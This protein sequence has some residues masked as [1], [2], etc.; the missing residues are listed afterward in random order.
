MSL[1]I[2]SLKQ[3]FDGKAIAL[4]QL[5]DP[6]VADLIKL[7]EKSLH[8]TFNP[9]GLDAYGS[10]HRV[11]QGGIGFSADEP[12]GTEHVGNCVAVIARDPLSGKTGLAHYDAL[13]TPESLQCLFDNL[14]DRKLDIV[15][16]GAMYDEDTVGDDYLRDTSASNLKDVLGFLADKNVNVVGARIHDPNQPTNFVVNPKDFSFAPVSPDRPNPDKDLAFARKFL[17]G[18]KQPLAIEFDL[19][20][21]KE[22]FPYLLDSEQVENLNT[23]V[24]GKNHEDV[25]AWHKSLGA[26][27]GVENVQADFSLGTYLPAYEKAL[28]SIISVF[29]E[30]DEAMVSAIRHRPMH[31]GTNSLAFNRQYHALPGSEA[32][33]PISSSHDFGRKNL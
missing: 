27:D 26:C 21:S 20:Q 33:L 6:F 5:P 29:G 12:I 30:G 25:V 1:D 9:K 32:S 16:I 28:E 2:G 4:S 24:R 31:I 18:Q 17:T 7:P 15:L 22:R 23:N 14:P 3:C 11:E 19:T 10:A 13:S 8:Q